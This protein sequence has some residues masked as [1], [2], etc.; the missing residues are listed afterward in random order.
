MSDP[1]KTPNAKTIAAILA[2]REWLVATGFGPEFAD[3]LLY[4]IARDQDR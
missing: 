3:L 2:Y 1:Q 4:G